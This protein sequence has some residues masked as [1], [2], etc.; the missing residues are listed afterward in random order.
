MENELYHY[1]VPGMKWGVIRSAYKAKS[2][3]RLA[4]RHLKY[5][6]KAFE[7]NRKSQNIHF[8]Q[9]L[10]TSN[11]L[12][13]KHFKYERKTV[14]YGE[15]ALDQNSNYKRS[16]YETKAAKAQLK[17][18][19]YGLKANKLAKTTG[20]GGKALRYSNQSDKAK[21]KSSRLLYKIAKNNKYIETTKN[22][23][24]TLNEDQ[25]NE[26]KKYVDKFNEAYEKNRFAGTAGT[27][28]DLIRVEV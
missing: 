3:D 8:K 25:L 15:K 2:N 5:K 16:L 7:L 17:S 28:K 1:G 27:P 12:S 24:S 11:R 21:I 10:K 26:G 4:K 18:D 22:K 23:L 20:Y 13:N 9:D 14:K 6:D 19:K